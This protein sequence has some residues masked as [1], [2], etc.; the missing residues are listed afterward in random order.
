METLEITDELRTKILRQ[1]WAEDKRLYRARKVDADWKSP[2]ASRVTPSPI[3]WLSG[4]AALQAIAQK[5]KGQQ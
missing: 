2:A 3:R 4:D 5:Q 1:R